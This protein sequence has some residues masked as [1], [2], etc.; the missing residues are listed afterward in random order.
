MRVGKYFLRG[1]ALVVL[2]L[3]VLWSLAAIATALR[4]HRIHGDLA[5][6]A[7]EVAHHQAHDRGEVAG[8]RYLALRLKHLKGPIHMR[9]ASL[10]TI[11]R[12]DV[13]LVEVRLSAVVGF[14][15]GGHPEVGISVVRIA[16]VE[17]GD[18]LP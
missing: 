13:L 14:A 3:S 9:S 16:P 10:R 7:Q 18:S 8:R 15:L 1:L 11:H 17:T 2:A 5:N 12:G 4:V 6:L